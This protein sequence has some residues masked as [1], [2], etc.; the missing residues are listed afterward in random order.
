MKRASGYLVI[1][2]VWRG[3]YLT[4]LR[5]EKV[6]SNKPKSG[7]FGAV[8]VHL[9]VDVPEHL[10]RPVEVDADLSVD[11]DNLSAVIARILPWPAGEDD[12][13]DADAG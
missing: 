8:V 4:G 10:F 11:A 3:T 7:T 9:S 13:V 2:P 6:T 1:K 12:E 5:F